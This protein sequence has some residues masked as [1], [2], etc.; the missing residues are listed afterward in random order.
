M[1]NYCRIFSPNED[2]YLLSKKENKKCYA[3]FGAQINPIHKN[4][5]KWN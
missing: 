4:E 3:R 5:M 1:L 2:N